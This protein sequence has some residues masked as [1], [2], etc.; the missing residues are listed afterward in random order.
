MASEVHRLNADGAE[1]PGWPV[2]LGGSASLIMDGGWLFV[3]ECPVAPSTDP[4]RLHRFRQDGT[5]EAGWPVR[6]MQHC[7][8]GVIAWD[9]AVVLQCG[10]GEVAQLIAIDRAAHLVAGWPVLVDNLREIGQAPGGSLYLLSA[11]PGGGLLIDV[12]GPDGRSRDGWPVELPNA[13]DRYGASG[14]LPDPAGFLVA[15][16][17]DGIVDGIC[18]EADRTVLSRLGPSGTA[19]PGWPVTIN[20]FGTRPVV[21]SNGGIWMRMDGPRS[22][23]VGLDSHGENLDGWP[24]DLPADACAGADGSAAAHLVSDGRLVV[25][26]DNIL[27][28]FEPDGAASPGWPLVLGGAAANGCYPSQCAPGSNQ[29]I[30]PVVGANGLMYMVLFRGSDAE[31]VARL[32]AF[33]R[34]ARSVV[35]WPLELPRLECFP[36][37][38][39]PFPAPQVYD[40]RLTPDG[41]PVVIAWEGIFWVR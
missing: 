9:G 5:E 16:W 3:S 15:W 14:V 35:G 7:Y 38:Y 23:V 25:V 13:G 32:E 4:C 18:L 11:P 19:A 26:Q 24:V 34:D 27:H 2:E 37:N 17:M 20:G 41:R 21:A 6:T 40:V 39:C 31:L 30:E 28:V 33:D 36:A 10:Q 1:L 29:V 12:R 8:G 22:M